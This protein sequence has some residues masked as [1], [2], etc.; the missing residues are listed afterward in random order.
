MKQKPSSQTACL[1]RNMAN[2]LN[3]VLAAAVCSTLA[4]ALPRDL[5]TSWYSLEAAKPVNVTLYFESLCPGC[6]QFI[7]QE[8]IPTWEKVK[9]TGLMN[10]TLRP[11]GNAIEEYKGGQWKFVCQHGPRECD[12]NVLEVCIIHYHPETNKQLEIIKCIESDF[13]ATEGQDWQATLKKC[14]STGVDVEKVSACAKGK[15]GN[16]L[17]HQVALNTGPHKWVPWVILD[18]TSS[19]AALDNLLKA[20]CEAYKGAP[21]SVCNM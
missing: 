14:A 6:H 4:V 18:G 11:Y 17:Q 19:E 21:P 2:I 20:V 10:V 5:A 1:T 12:G 3:L 9:D 15:E 7:L 13:Y 8:L 16:V